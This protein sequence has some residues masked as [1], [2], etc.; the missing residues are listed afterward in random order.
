MVEDAIDTLLMRSRA[1]AQ[2]AR[3]H[4][5]A[6]LLTT[7]HDALTAADARARLCAAPTPSSSPR[8]G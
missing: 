6:D 2:L 1:E 5:D 7:H 4:T 3:L 8:A